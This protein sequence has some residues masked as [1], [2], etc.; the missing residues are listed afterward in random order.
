MIRWMLDPN[1]QWVLMG[2][3]LLGISSGLLSSFAML[4][5]R[6]LLGDALAHASLPG[7]CAAFLLTGERSI[8]LFMLGALVAGIL[9]ALFIQGI[10]KYSRI[11]EDTALGLVL[12]VFFAVGIVL[13]TRILHSNTGTQ[14]GLDKFLFGQAAALIGHD[15]QVMLGCTALILFVT[16]ML[17]KELKL[18]CFDPGFAG[19]LGFPPGLIDG[20]LNLLLVLIV[21]VG[22][23]AVG[24]ILMVALLITPAA[25]ARFWTSRLSRMV[26]LSALTGGLSGMLGT[27]LS[28]LAPHLPTGPLI[29]LS[30]S[31]LFVVSLFLAPR[32]GLIA[33]SIRLWRLRKKVARENLLRTLYE[34]AEQQGTW[35]NAFG[36]EAL[37]EFRHLS[38]RRMLRTLERLRQEGLVQENRQQF[39]L[40]HAG[41]EE[42]YQVTRNHRLWEMF[43]MHEEQLK[44]DHV[45]R[46]ADLIE[47]FLPREIVRELEQL[48]RIHDRQLKL[49]ASVHP[50]ET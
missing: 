31:F 45:D 43:L 8:P 50:L 2:C 36:V 13:L 1:A 27:G 24:A 16:G 39:Q 5:R 12:S 34:L 25:A 30:L 7:V 40:T 26:T 21:V 4:R 19:S 10:T 35:D 18:L 46:D 37:A 33:K 14:S 38:L 22:L 32:R 23:Q 47:H 17:Y 15:V 29:V 41:L 9:G 44:A 42:A 6:S 28:T 49:P 20:L 11:K 48:M 3:T